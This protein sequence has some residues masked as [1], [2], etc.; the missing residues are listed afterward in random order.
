MIAG[1]RRITDSTPLK[2]PRSAP[3]ATPAIAAIHG[4]RPATMRS[5]ITTA[6]KLNI[7]PTERSI[8]RMASR[9]T[10]PIASM[11]RK[12]VWPRTVRRLIGLRKCGRATPMTTIIATSATMT[13]ISSGRRKRRVARAGVAGDP[14]GGLTVSAIGLVRS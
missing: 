11:P 14:L 9:N 6:E 7:Q 5:A 8:S 1:N 4:L 3:K 12:V 2:R 10:M 13:P